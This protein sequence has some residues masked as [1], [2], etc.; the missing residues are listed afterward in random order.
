[1]RGCGGSITRLY[2]TSGGWFGGGLGMFW[3]CSGD[4]LGM[5]GRCLEGVWKVFGMFWGWLEGVWVWL[6]VVWDM[7][8]I[9]LCRL[10][11]VLGT[12]V[13]GTIKNQ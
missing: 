12:G 13:G 5:F 2:R 1:M 4:V 10:G 8:L 7:F 3:G 9:V 6:S 11:T